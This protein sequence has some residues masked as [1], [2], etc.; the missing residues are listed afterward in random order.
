MTTED[1]VLSSEDRKLFKPPSRAMRCRQMIWS[2]AKGAEKPVALSDLVRD[3]CEEYRRSEIY[4]A[5]RALVIHGIL[6]RE[7]VS[8]FELVNGRE[9]RHHRYGVRYVEPFRNASRCW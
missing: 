8:W 3:H 6:T 7:D 2:I 4:R 1:L 5:A 9:R